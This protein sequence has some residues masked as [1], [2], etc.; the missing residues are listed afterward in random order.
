MAVSV[1]CSWTFD[2]WRR[3][4]RSRA[5]CANRTGI[6]NDGVKVMGGSTSSGSL[7]STHGRDNLLRFLAGTHAD[8]PGLRVIFAPAGV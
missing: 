1:R 7:S 2:A 8:T 6:S 4:A 3:K 5:A